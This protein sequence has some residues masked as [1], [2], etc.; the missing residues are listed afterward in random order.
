MLAVVSNTH[1]YK[2]LSYLG[3]QKGDMIVL[4]EDIHQGVPLRYHTHKIVLLKAAIREYEKYLEHEGYTVKRIGTQSKKGQE[5]LR[6]ILGDKDVKEVAMPCIEDEVYRKELAE[7]CRSCEVTIQWKQTP[8][9]LTTVKEFRDFLGEYEEIKMQ[10]FYIWQ[11]KRLNL[12]LE[13]DGSPCGGKWS[14]DAD[15]RK[16]LPKGTPLEPLPTQSYSSIT[17]QVIEEVAK[18]YP[19][20]PGDPSSFYLPTTFEAA[21]EWLEDFLRRRFANFGPYEDA[22]EMHEPF[23]FHSLLSPIINIGLLTPKQVI[24]QAIT[25]AETHEVPMQ[26]LEGFVRQVIGWREFL[27]GIYHTQ[28]ERKNFFTHSRKLTPAWYEGNTGILPLDTVIK[29]VMK[30]GYAH[31]I[32]RLMVLSNMMVLCEIDPEDVYRWFMELFV[33]AYDWVMVPNVFGMGQFADGGVYATKPYISGSNYIRKMSHFPK[34]EWE[35]VWDG[36]YWRFV[37]KH[38][39][40][41]ETQA[42]SKMMVKH[43]DTMD[44][45]RLKR[46]LALAEE[47][48]ERITA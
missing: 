33:D 1:L 13:P 38:R 5:E 22:I 2:N 35:D 10:Y 12:L 30:Y 27:R 32:E 24:D 16:K 11:R 23:L 9:F 48:I 18:E 26:S 43:L 4:L 29:R 14:Y 20:Y 45:E 6:A 25:Y 3:I 31:H 15:N 17:K 8:A 42:R 44:Q 47:C 34:G 46:I 39:T 21:E 19:D 36:L 28:E 7:L 37:K 40:F 41:F